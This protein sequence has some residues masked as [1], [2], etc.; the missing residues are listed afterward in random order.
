MRPETEVFLER[1]RD[2][3]DPTRADEQRVWLALRANLAAASAGNLQAAPE[4]RL[5]GPGEPGGLAGFGARTLG[6]FG[7]KLHVFLLC[8]AAALGTGDTPHTHARASAARVSL[9]SRAPDTPA[10][11]D[12][13]AASPAPEQPPN[14]GLSP[15]A[16]R[17]PHGEAGSRATPAASSRPSPHVERASAPRATTPSRARREPSLRAELDLLQRVQDALRRGD[18]AAALQA[19]DAH[20]THDRS[21]LAERQAARVLALCNLGRVDEARRAAARFEAQHPGSVQRDVI[22]RSCVKR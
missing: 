12:P 16:E 6:A 2:A 15:G 17:P 10:A 14:E 8:G 19:L 13:P 3:E 18:G 21:L 4:P 11:F 5:A 1:V 20:Q 9:G 7:S 22:T